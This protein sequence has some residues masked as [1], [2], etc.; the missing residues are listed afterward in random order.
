VADYARGAGK[1][2]KILCLVESVFQGHWAVTVH[3]CGR[4]DTH[5]GIR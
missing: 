2:L 3:G 4:D 1:L 5:V